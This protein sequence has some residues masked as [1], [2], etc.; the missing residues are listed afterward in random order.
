VITVLQKLITVSHGYYQPYFYWMFPI[1]VAKEQGLFEKLG[2]NLKVHDIGEQ[3]QP[4]DKA[5]W[6]KQALQ[7]RSRDFYFCCAWQGIYSTSETGKGRI[8]AAI[9]ST[10]LKTF[11][12]YVR[13]DGPVKNIIDLAEKGIAVAVNRNADAHYVTLK[14]LSEFI[15]SSRVKLSHL[16]GVERCFRALVRREVDA[17]TLAGPYAEAAEAMGYSRLLPLSRTEPTVVVFNDTLDRKAASHF[18]RAL[19]E[20]INLIAKDR[21]TYRQRYIEEFKH[22][23]QLYIPELKRRLPIITPKLTLPVWAPVEPLAQEEFEEI[24][25]FLQ[26]HGLSAGRRGYDETVDSALLTVG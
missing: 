10:L 3:G 7:E 25:S 21:E 12:I 2:L 23:I 4:E 5:N 9:R 14:N 24:H 22:V 6:Y 17:A 13:P 16:G 11:A 20:A 1:I 8:G 15:P 19:N 26:E 18:I